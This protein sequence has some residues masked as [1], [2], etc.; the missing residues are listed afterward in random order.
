MRVEEEEVEE[1]EKEDEVRLKLRSDVQV[2]VARYSRL[3]HGEG[4]AHHTLARLI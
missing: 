3:P 4:K 2:E 1:S